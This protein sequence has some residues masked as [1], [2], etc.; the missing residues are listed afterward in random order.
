[1][2]HHLAAG[3]EKDRYSTLDFKG[4]QYLV[5]GYARL[6]SDEDENPCLVIEVTFIEEAC[7]RGIKI[8]FKDF[9]E[10]IRVELSEMPGEDVLM[11]ALNMVSDTDGGIIMN[12]IKEIGAVEVFNRAAYTKIAPVIRGHLID[13]YDKMGE[14][15]LWA[16]P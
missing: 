8:F 4:E 12:K 9:L 11:G 2:M 14:N 5:A 15:V 1:M 10:H 7:R 3:F 16:R 13:S 6:S